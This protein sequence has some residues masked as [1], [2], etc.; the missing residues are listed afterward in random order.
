M[1]VFK[2]SGKELF[3]Y[4]DSLFPSPLH[5][6]LELTEERNIVL[7]MLVDIW[8]NEHITSKPLTGDIIVGEDEIVGGIFFKNP[9]DREA[10]ETWFS[11]LTDDDVPET[12]LIPFNP[13]YLLDHEESLHIAGRVTHVFHYIDDPQRFAET[14]YD[15]CIWLLKHSSQ[16]KGK[17]IWYDDI[18]DCFFFEDAGA[19]VSFK[20]KFTVDE[21]VGEAKRTK[22]KAKT[23]ARSDDE[24]TGVDHFGDTLDNIYRT[25]VNKSSGWNDDG[26]DYHYQK[27]RLMDAVRKE[28]SNRGY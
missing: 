23:K 16:E 25:Y 2:P 28:R 17:R 10:F 20:L 27:Q 1:A 8:L 3:E 6:D 9:G 15:I 21:Q 4:R 22:T 11:K 7:K 26:D 12:I 13:D 19:A 24:S 18:R 5:T 14:N